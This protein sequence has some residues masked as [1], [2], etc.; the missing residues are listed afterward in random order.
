M[1]GRGRFYRRIAGSIVPVLLAA[2][3]AADAEI[4]YT[5]DGVFDLP[6]PATVGAT[7][8]WMT[9]AMVEAPHHL[10]IAD[11][12]VTVSL[13]HERVFD[14]QLFLEGPSGTR[15]LLNMYDPSQDWGEG[16]GYDGTTFDDEALVPIEAATAP[17]QGTYRP[18]AG[19]SLTVFDGQDA[20]GPWRLQVYDAYY[21]AAG[22]FGSYS[23][24]VTVPEPA[25]V[26][27]L[28][29][30]LGWLARAGRRRRG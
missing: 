3:G 28:L 21:G 27:L 17:F 20:C 19:S 15:V 26:I 12:D 18:L 6:I 2:V 7:T 30:G 24:A 5:Y 9:D 22:H 16:Q 8:G 14:V 1:S 25:T 4:V 23:L 11:L 10:T 13:S 29:P